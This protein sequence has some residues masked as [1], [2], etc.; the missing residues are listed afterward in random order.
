MRHVFVEETTPGEPPS[1]PEFQR[2]SGELEE[3][4][5]S[6]DAGKEATES[7]G[8]RDF[9]EQYRSNEESEL[10]VSYYQYD[11]PLS[12]TGDIVDPVGFTMQ[13]PDGDF[14]SLT[15][16]SRRDVKGGGKL[17]GGFREYLVALGCRPVSATLDGDPSAAEAIPQELT[18]PAETIRPHIIHQP[19][20]STELVVR[21]TDAGDTNE[22]VI[23]D[24]G[25]NTSSTLTL[26]GSS[27]NTAATTVTFDDID[28]VFCRGEHAGDVQLGTDNGSGSIDTELLETPLTGTN[29]DRVSSVEG[30][31]PLEA[32]TIE[33]PPTG[34]GNT[35]L[36]TQSSFNGSDIAPRLH[37][38]DLSVE[39]DTAREA[40]Q[41]SR[42]T[43]IDVGQRTVEFSA[44][45][46]GPFQSAAKIKAHFRD[47][48]GDLIYAF[49]DA[50]TDPSVADRKIVA[51]NVEILDA[52]DHTRS[53]GDTNFIPSVEFRAV[54]DEN[55][56]AI[57]MINNS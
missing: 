53:A 28:S 8:D 33:A 54:S 49:D 52:P 34:Q 29:Q 47:V 23:E 11:F 39:L 31:P 37:T 32:G 50:G 5:A 16:V 22:I 24:E 15:H 25:A 3:V 21:S 6:I 20:T 1:D 18:M 2:Y 7:L 40:L 17:G 30:I 56:P 42:R 35:F 43:E 27:P 12:N 26:P 38:L 36:G 55:N 45:V 9:V 13:L 46:A 19:A 48:S 44:D 41:S 4:S 51:H 57:E 14:P 10:T